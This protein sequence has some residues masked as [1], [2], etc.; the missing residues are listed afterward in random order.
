[1]TKIEE[2]TGKK[3]MD[4]KVVKC[5]SC[6]GKLEI[7][8][9]KTLISCVYCGSIVKAQEVLRTQSN[10]RDFTIA[11]KLEKVRDH[12]PFNPAPV[13]LQTNVMLG[14]FGSFGLIA[15]ALSGGSGVV[16]LIGL[17]I[18]GLVPVV[19]TVRT[20][21]LNKII[22]ADEEFAKKGPAVSVIGYEG[23]CPYCGTVVT[24]IANVSGETCPACHKRYLIR[25]SKFFSVETPVT[26]NR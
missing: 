19:Y 18:L 9:G 21:N 26:G 23:A 17:V 10:V 5:P 12:V 24:A 13:K 11:T 20:N 22:A 2:R 25:D 7:E 14:L 1:M 3:T 6:G 16:I 4:F 8:E 15:L